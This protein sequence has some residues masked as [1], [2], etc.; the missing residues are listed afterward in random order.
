M[1]LECK[2]YKTTAKGKEKERSSNCTKEKGGY[3][4]E[5][6]ELQG[7]GDGLYRAVDA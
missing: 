2:F 7:Q 4:T 1:S 5:N 6:E 3:R